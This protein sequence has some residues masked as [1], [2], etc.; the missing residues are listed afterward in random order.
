VLSA[1]LQQSCAVF[2]EIG[3]TKNEQNINFDHK[4]NPSQQTQQ[5]QQ[6]HQTHQTIQTNSSAPYSLSALV[7]ESTHE[8]ISNNTGFNFPVLSNAIIMPITP[9]TSISISISNALNPKKHLETF[10]HTPPT[11]YSMFTDSLQ[12][13][14]S[15]SRLAAMMALLNGNMNV[16]FIPNN[17]NNSCFNDLYELFEEDDHDIMGT[18]IH[19]LYMFHK[20][21]IGVDFGG[22][23]SDHK[24]QKNL[25]EFDQNS[26]NISRNKIQV[27]TQ[28]RDFDKILLDYRQTQASFNKSLYRDAQNGNYGQNSDQNIIINTIIDDEQLL[29]DEKYPTAA[30]SFIN[31]ANLM[32][33]PLS[34]IENDQN[35][36]HDPNNDEFNTI[37]H[38]NDENMNPTHAGS[39]STHSIQS[40]SPICAQNA[41][42]NNTNGKNNENVHKNTP[43]IAPEYEFIQYTLDLTSSE[44]TTDEEDS[45]LTQSKDKLQESLMASVIRDHHTTFPLLR[46]FVEDKMNFLSTRLQYS[47][48]SLDEIHNELIKLHFESSLEMK[49]ISTIFDPKFAIFK[50]KL[51]EKR[52]NYLLKQRKIALFLDEQIIAPFSFTWKINYT[53]LGFET[54]TVSMTV[55]ERLGNNNEEQE[56]IYRRNLFL[57]NRNPNFNSN[58]DNAQNYQNNSINSIQHRGSVHVQTLQGLCDVINKS[59]N[60]HSRRNCIKPSLVSTLQRR[61][62]TKSPQ[63]GMNLTQKRD[64][65]RQKRRGLRLINNGLDN[66]DKINKNDQNEVLLSSNQRKKLLKML[67]N[68]QNNN[69][70]GIDITRSSSTLSKIET[71]IQRDDGERLLYI[72]G[73]STIEMPLNSPKNSHLLPSDP[74]NPSQALTPQSSITKLLKGQSRQLLLSPRNTAGV[75]GKGLMTVSEEKNAKKNASTS[76]HD[77]HGSSNDLDHDGLLNKTDTTKKESKHSFRWFG[78]KD[79]KT[80]LS[81]PRRLLRDEINTHVIEDS[82]SGDGSGNDRSDSSS[83]TEEIKKKG[84]FSFLNRDKKDEKDEKI[85]KIEKNPKKTN[86]LRNSSTS[87]NVDNTSATHDVHN[88]SNKS[89]KGDFNLFDKVG[90][91][92]KGNLFSRHQKKI[93]DEAERQQR[94]LNKIDNNLDTGLLDK[95]VQKLL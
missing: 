27:H 19:E 94:L 41:S 40:T 11:T 34:A 6:T 49:K 15:P 53:T 80:D 79:K 45:E 30:S 82:D 51:I 39:I 3:G 65:R 87:S 24:N 1:Q 2:N 23:K 17:Q 59:Y 25:N 29:N 13:I 33:S 91:S 46:S 74:Q 84:I 64:L 57:N 95:D 73:V 18:S 8:F 26:D 81:P 83:S 14:L 67:K 78:K 20:L 61:N 72:N 43:Q 77:L 37:F 92:I 68:T 50:R 60:Y 52:K 63:M 86:S 85:E 47:L 70:N 42:K 90:S 56:R 4:N 55:L 31:N 93:Q 44:S 89:L 7:N 9:K 21:A 71:M 76:Q 62:S 48:K 54:E 35:D 32:L 5:T 12:F 58:Y 88:Q 66:V 38:Y 16:S 36:Q 28:T 22:P 75:S 10:P 69:N